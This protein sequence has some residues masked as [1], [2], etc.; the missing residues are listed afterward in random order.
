VRRVR[1]AGEDVAGDGAA[2]CRSTE[3]V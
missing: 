3:V 2:L 1:P